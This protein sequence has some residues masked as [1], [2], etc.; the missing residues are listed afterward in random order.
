Q[1]LHYAAAHL[2]ADAFD[3]DPNLANNITSRLQGWLAS[4]D[5]PVGRLEELMTECRFPAAR[6][7]ALVGCGLGEGTTRLADTERA[8]RRKQAGDWLR[9]DLD[10]WAKTLDHGSR[11]S[12]VL[13]RDKLTHWLTDPDFART[14]DTS[15]LQALPAKERD[16]WLTLWQKVGALV[17][18]A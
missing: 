12:R 13:V 17:E 14:R 18:R 10:Y 4:A 8:R 7:A 6:S 9:A 15:V 16:E 1:G 5:Q 3:T 11:A 2:Y